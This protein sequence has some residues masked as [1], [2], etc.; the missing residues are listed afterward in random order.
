MQKE[1]S[2]PSFLLYLLQNVFKELIYTF[3]WEKFTRMLIK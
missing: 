2:Y 3:I 1:G